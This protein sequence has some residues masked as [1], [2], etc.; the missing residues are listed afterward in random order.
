MGRGQGE[1]QAC[2]HCGPHPQTSALAPHPNRLPD[3]RRGEG[4]SGRTL[5]LTPNAPKLLHRI[6]RA[7]LA[8]SV[9]AIARSVLVRD[10]MLGRCSRA[11]RAA[12]GLARVDFAHAAF[13]CAFLLGLFDNHH[14]LRLVFAGCG[15]QR[16]CH[17][18]CDPGKRPIQPR[19]ALGSAQYES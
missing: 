11:I 3:I 18:N 6:T 15:L 17:D 19:F 1:G 12:I 2:Q 5:L 4:V 7:R 10:F 9:A 14:G 16:M 13:V 8:R